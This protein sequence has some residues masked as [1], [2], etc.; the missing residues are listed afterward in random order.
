MY[1]NTDIRGLNGDTVF[2]YAGSASIFE[3][4]M[5]RR[6]AT[7]W[8]FISRCGK[9]YYSFP[10]AWGNMVG[11]G[12]DPRHH[13]NRN[14]RGRRG[15]LYRDITISGRFGK[16]YCRSLGYFPPPW[17]GISAT[18]MTLR[19]GALWPSVWSIDWNN[20]TFEEGGFPKYSKGE[21]NGRWVADPLHPPP[22]T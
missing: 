22:L 16:P 7:S 3:E 4:K 5:I 10:Q 2:S 1:I 14:H 18:A 20:A 13:N 8:H 12:T 19:P 11:N 9:A 15:V 6:I 17:F 21:S